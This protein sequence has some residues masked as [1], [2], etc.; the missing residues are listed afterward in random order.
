MGEPK[1][2]AFVLGLFD[3]GL[4]A[5]RALARAGIP[6]YGFDSTASQPGFTSRYG[7]PALCPDPADDPTALVQLL[8]ER[9]RSCAVPPVIYATSDRFVHFLSEYRE[10]LHP[11]VRHA[12]P[13]RDA[14]AA[15]LDKRQQF[16]RAADAGVPVVPTYWPSTAT[17]LRAIAGSLPFPVV[18]KPV[19]GRVLDA[20]FHGAKAVRVSA[21]DHLLRLFEPIFARGD[22]A[23]LQRLIVGPNTNHYKVCAYI[24]AGGRPLACIGMRKIRQF[25]VDFGVGTL[26]ESADD[27]E[28]AQ[29]GLRL[30]H[31]LEWRGPVSIEFKRDERDGAWRLIELNPRLWQQHGLAARC[32]VNFPLLQYAD[33]TGGQPAAGRYQLGVRWLDESRD[34]RS[35]WEHMR[36]GKLTAGQWLAS[37]ARVRAGALFALDDP[38]PFLGAVVGHIGGVWKH[39]ERRYDTWRQHLRR[40]QRKAFRHAR[41]VLDEGALSP[42]VNTS[43]LETH[44]VNELFAASAR[45]LGLQCRFLD[46]VLILEHEH[47]PVLRMCGVYNDLDGFAAGVICGDKTLSRRVLA[48]A[49]CPIP[50]GRSFRWDQER[51]AL[52]FALSLHTPC[53]TKPARNTSSSAGVS[54]ELRTRADIVRGFR[55]SS[56][57]SDDI[58]IEE[59]VAGEDYRLLVYKGQCLSVLRRLRP[60]VMGNG[61]DS[62]QVLIQ[63]EN[64][65]RIASAEWHVGDPELMPLK[66]DSRTRR[67]LA[68]QGLSLSSVPSR[69]QEVVLS[70][71]AN[72]GIG[73]SYV[74]CIDTTHYEIIEGAMVAADAA[75]VVLAGIDVIAADISRSSYVINEINTTPSTELHYFVANRA[76]ARNPF[77]VILRDLVTHT[78]SSRMF[79]QHASVSVV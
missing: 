66:T 67:Y 57:Y 3:T 51:Q 30:C 6:V 1:A 54:V 24:D 29:M 53:V 7:R 65:N 46:D 19:Q 2:D 40:L 42:K 55:R 58:L 9:A 31:A 72:F 8:V 56:L 73:A 13:C 49:G 34:P 27:P 41:R 32:G 5:V 4:A 62:I 61:H 63:R 77:T 22:T 36:R 60:R 33:L 76:D 21:L 69:G 79:R 59:H 10:A 52:D 17:E 64:A 39:L 35:A 50:R 45:D 78:T 20:P 43:V 74:E 15:A 25:P 16:I 18:V 14:V 68:A 71:L 23:L 37:L 75:G 28:L 70:R 38:R 47:G 26:M 48:E 44:M 12:L 11:Y